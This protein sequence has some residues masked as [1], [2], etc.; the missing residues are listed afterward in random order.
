MKMGNTFFSMCQSPGYGKTQL[1]EPPYSDFNYIL[2]LKTQFEG[3]VQNF[4]DDFLA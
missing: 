3:T 4:K 1:N 2:D